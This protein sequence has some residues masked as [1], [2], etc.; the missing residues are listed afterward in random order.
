MMPPS[1]TST[2][3][4]TPLAIV[5]VN[6]S[7]ESCAPVAETLSNIVRVKLSVPIGAGALTAQSKTPLLRTQFGDPVVRFATVAAMA[8]L[9]A[10]PLT[11]LTLIEIDFVELEM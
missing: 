11:V 1:A 5:A 6:V 3:F 2:L 9:G 4:A 10:D 8:G 7:V